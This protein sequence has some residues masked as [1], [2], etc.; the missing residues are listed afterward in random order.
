MKLNYPQ[1]KLQNH[2]TESQYREK[3]Q[4]YIDELVDDLTN[5]QP[6]EYTSEYGKK[7]FEFYNEQNIKI[8]NRLYYNPQFEEIIELLNTLPE[9]VY[10]VGGFC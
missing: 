1:Q 2:I 9:E 6:S 5:K 4:N 7:V 8:Q 10:V 3:P